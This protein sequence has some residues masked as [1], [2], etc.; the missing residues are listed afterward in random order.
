MLNRKKGHKLTGNIL[1]RTVL[2]LTIFLNVTIQFY[3]YSFTITFKTVH[4][5]TFVVRNVTL[6]SLENRVEQH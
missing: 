5:N 2:G 3:Y 6:S 1:L 4:K